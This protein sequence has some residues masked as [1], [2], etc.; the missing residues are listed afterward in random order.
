MHMARSVAWPCSSCAYWEPY[1]AWD[2]VGTCD[3]I[4]SPYYSRMAVGGAVPCE[5][6][7][8]RTAAVRTE[9]PSGGGRRER[10]RH[11]GTTC[12]L[13]HYWY[14]FTL[15]PQVGECDNPSSKHFREPEFSDKQTEECFVE[16]SLDDLD[17]MWCQSHRQTIY[18]AELP[19]H[20]RCLVYVSSA[21][22]PVEEE[23]ELTLAGD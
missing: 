8:S 22:L 21:S 6:Y 14:P 11:G 20:R 4:M 9:N 5:Y 15:M 18:S 10:P 23:P 17:F 13:C 3:R 16:R 12:M 19:D 7:A 2:G 1:P